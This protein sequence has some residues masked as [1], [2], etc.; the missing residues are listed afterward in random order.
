MKAPAAGPLGPRRCK[1]PGVAVVVAAAVITL[2]APLLGGEEPLKV[3]V[4]DSERAD[5]PLWLEFGTALKSALQAGSERPVGIYFENLDS[6]RFGDSGYLDR[7]A[8]WLIE[9][10]RSVRPDVIVTVGPETYRLV[11]RWPA[12]LAAETSVVGVAVDRTTFSDA[13][14][15]PRTTGLIRDF[16][17][18]ETVQIALELFPKTR[19]LA[20]VG[21]P[22][23]PKSYSRFFYSQIV[24]EF[25]DELDIIDLSGLS[26]EE[27]RARAAR[28]PD[29]TVLVLTAMAVDGDGRPFTHPEVVK[30]VAPVANA[31][32]FGSIGTEL[33]YGLVGGHLFDPGMMGRETAKLVARILNGEPAESIEP[34]LADLSVVAFDWRELERWGIAERRLP[35][36][37]VVEFRPPT[38]W[39][40]HRG[41]LLL[42]IAVFALQ[43]VSILALLRS[44]DHRKRINRELHELSGRLISAQE[45]ERR[46]VA[47]E[48][49]DDV[50]QRLALLAIEL[51]MPVAGE[52]ERLAA[53]SSRVQNLARDVHAIAHHLQPPRLG[54]GG[55]AREIEAFCD[56]VNARHELRVVCR[57]PESTNQI[58]GDSALALYRVAQEAV[59]NA[60]KHSGADEVALELGV[61]PRWASL[62]VADNGRGFESRDLPPG[63]HLGM[64]S[65]RERMRQVKGW[66]NIDSA[67]GAGTTVSAWVPMWSN[68]KGDGADD[69]PADPAR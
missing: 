5:L 36:G 38:L 43:S 8:G 41:A 24:A 54:E 1:V 17:Q 51:E 9:K 14:R 67:P 50:S 3:L 52:G 21:G 25:G 2:A 66:L 19:H 61:S 39:D 12:L 69:P 6:A 58:A 34:R 27:I 28:L 55:L 29:D 26:L 59:Q 57:L 47:R 37:S 18:A 64:A 7:V 63:R 11:T 42:A 23:D 31:P 15:L 56:E 32:M 48:L 10:Y 40:E 45:D 62:T 46:R 16:A 22:K 20:I 44:R 13:G 65:M 68:L 53:V 33:G 35:K 30:E 60:V 49:H 4:I